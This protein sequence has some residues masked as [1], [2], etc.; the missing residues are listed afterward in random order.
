[1]WHFNRV[2]L[3]WAGPAAEHAEHRALRYQP[4]ERDENVL[5]ANFSLSG[6]IGLHSEP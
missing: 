6:I 5:I 1:M 3:N 4:I 2:L